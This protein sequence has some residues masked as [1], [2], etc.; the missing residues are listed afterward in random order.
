M[1]RAPVRKTIG[2]APASAVGDGLAAGQQH[3]DAV[4]GRV[5]DGDSGEAVGE[6]AGDGFGGGDAGLLGAQAAERFGGLDAVL[7]RI[8]A[9]V[10][11]ERLRA[12]EGAVGG[13][14][15]GGED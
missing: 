14:R 9:G 5:L 3:D 6:L 11:L 7:D 8:L 2:T 10:L 4:I 1:A 15:G 12:G 13:R